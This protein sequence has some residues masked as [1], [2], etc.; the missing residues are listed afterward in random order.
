LVDLIWEKNVEE[1]DF[2]SNHDPK[3]SDNRRIPK[4]LSFP[5]LHIRQAP[6]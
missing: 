6:D 4:M 3:P 2:P 5:F 1:A